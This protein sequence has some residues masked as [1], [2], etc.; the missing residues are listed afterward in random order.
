MYQ[1]SKKIEL[2]VM[3]TFWSCPL[4]PVLQGFTDLPAL[5]LK[6]KTP[7]AK[8]SKN[9]APPTQPATTGTM[10]LEELLLT[11]GFFERGT[12]GGGAEETCRAGGLLR[13][14]CNAEDSLVVVPLWEGTEEDAGARAATGGRS[15][16]KWV[17][18]LRKRPSNFLWK[19]TPLLEEKKGK[20]KMSL[21]QR[22]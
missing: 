11:L 21:R 2:P 6:K 7:V 10:L 20:M 18:G 22:R 9:T 14:G 16:F 15:L 3:N 1:V 12:E 19:L 17:Y 5:L 8:R 13:G 4:R